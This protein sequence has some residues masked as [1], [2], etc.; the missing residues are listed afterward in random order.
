[1][2]NN[3]N[4][5]QLQTF[6]PLLKIKLAISIIMDCLHLMYALLISTGIACG[7]YMAYNSYLQTTAPAEQTKTT[8]KTNQT[9]QPTKSL[10]SN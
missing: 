7:I 1:M 3:I 2:D 9:K 4:Y 5:P 10:Q 6:S 8:I